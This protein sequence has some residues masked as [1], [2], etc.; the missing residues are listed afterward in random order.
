MYIIP[1][2]DLIDG[3][4][5]RLI[6]GEYNRRI[7]YRNSPVEQ[8]NQFISDGAQWVHI[9]DLD[10]AKLGKPINTAT[11][12][13]IAGLDRL[14]IEVGGGIREQD[15]IEQLLDIGIQRVIIGTKAVNDFEWFG[16]RE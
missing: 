14:K 6:Q 15:S 1:A 11:I 4:C 16:N 12:A 10:G 2:I 5:V 13:Q 9:V 3:K 8:A 7:T